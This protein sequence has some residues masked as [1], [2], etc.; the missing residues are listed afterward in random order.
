MGERPGYDDRRR[1]LEAGLARLES[2]AVAVSGGVDSAVLLHAALAALGPR[3]VGVVADSPSLARRELADARVVARQIGARLVEVTTDEGADPAYRA[4]RGDRCYFCKA[5]LFRAMERVCRAEGIAAMA[6]GEIV[7]D[8][9]DDRPGAR[10]ARE[11]SV[12]APLSAA[13]LDKSDVRRYAREAGLAVA[14]KEASACLASR[15]PVGTAVTRERLAAVERAEDALRELGLS[16]LRV[17]HLGTRARL[18][19]GAE[20]RDAA[21]RMAPRIAAA[22]RRAGFRG[23][24]LATYVP[25]AER[26][27]GS[28]PPRS[29][30]PGA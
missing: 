25:P 19:V 15:I 6:F 10:A 16:V 26:A 29:D 17:R 3:A 9:A 28:A 18:E 23:H 14:D 30:S 7:D 5:A 21:R 11:L 20:E 8:W 22:L 2:V 4:N 24:E 13:G 12:V 1:A 27:S